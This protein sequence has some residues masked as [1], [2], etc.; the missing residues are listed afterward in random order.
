[1]TKKITKGYIYLITPPDSLQ[2]DGG[3]AT[4]N[5]NTPAGKTSSYPPIA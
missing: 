3:P 4:R 1:M 5:G 2:A